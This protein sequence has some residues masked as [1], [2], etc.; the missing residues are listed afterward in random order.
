MDKTLILSACIPFL[1]FGWAIPVHCPSL[2]FSRSSLGEKIFAMTS[3]TLY[4][5]AIY[6]VVVSL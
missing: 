1:I 3:I 5:A 2:L 4:A 6:G